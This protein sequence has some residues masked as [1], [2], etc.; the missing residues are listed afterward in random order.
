MGLFSFLKKTKD[1]SGAICLDVL[2]MGGFWV[3]NGQTKTGEVLD[4]LAEEEDWKDFVESR[5][6]WTEQQKLK[7]RVENE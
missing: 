2:S 5:R 6:K 7:Q 3:V 1:I 4:S